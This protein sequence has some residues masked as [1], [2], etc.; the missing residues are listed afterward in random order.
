MEWIRASECFYSFKTNLISYEYKI[1]EKKY[2]L[3]D[4]VL[5]RPE[6]K[7]AYP[8]LNEP[9]LLL[10]Y[11]VTCRAVHDSC[12][13]I[14]GAICACIFLCQIFAL[15]SMEVSTD[16]YQQYN[17]SDENYCQDTWNEKITVCYTPRQRRTCFFLEVQRTGG[18]KHLLLKCILFLTRPNHFN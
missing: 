17:K 12:I 5:Y 15:M 3:Y 2:L 10:L 8:L 13:R 14:E 1:F 7:L 18:T 16:E 9:F 11:V 4:V 6:W